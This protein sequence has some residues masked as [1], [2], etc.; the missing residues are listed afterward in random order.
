MDRIPLSPPTIA[1]VPGGARRPRWSVM[2]PVYNCA[3][4]LK[5]TMEAV[6]AQALPQEDMQIEVVDD[7]STDADVEALVLSAGKGRISY[8]R[9]SENKGSLRNFETCINRASGHLIHLLHGDDLIKPG[10]Y[11]AMDELFDRYPE[12]GAA[13]C[14]YEYIGESSKRLYYRDEEMKEA[15]ILP[16]ALLLLA[17]RQRLQF[18]TVTVK[19]E[20]YEKLGAFFGVEYGEDWEMW[21]RIARDYPIAYTP[22]TLASYRL[23]DS[24][25]SGKSYATARNLKDLQWVM[26]SIQE[27]MPEAEKARVMEQSM[28]FYAHYGIK[29]ANDLWYG[30]R[31]REGAK[32]QVAEALRMHRDWLMYWK[33]TKLYTKM[34]LNITSFIPRSKK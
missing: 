26:R 31:N 23:H 17:V 10:Y 12:A 27:Y 2:I 11:Q 33:I 1:P 20:V 7:H 8:F 32:V 22:R 29:I 14:R 25:I 19:R 4:F 9:Q 21:V 28:K 15:G 6:L 16:D 24:S 13:F 5:E 3:N 18:C 34:A 30:L